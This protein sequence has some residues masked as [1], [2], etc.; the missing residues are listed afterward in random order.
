[1]KYVS[2]PYINYEL[3]KDIVS[4][5]DALTDR[6]KRFGAITDATEQ[7]DWN[8][9]VNEASLGRN[10]VFFDASGNP[11][12]LV[13]VESMPMNLLQ[14]GWE[15]KSHYAFIVNNVVKDRF[16]MGKYQGV[17][18]GSGAESRVVCLRGLDPGNSDWSLQITFDD[19]LTA[20]IQSGLCLATNAM[21][22]FIALR[23]LARG[24]MPRGNNNYGKDVSV[25]SETAVPSFIYSNQVARCATGTGP[26]SWADDGTPFGIFDIN[27]NVWE[28]AAGLRLLDGEI[29][30]IPDNNAALSTTDMSVSSTAW[31]AIMPDGTLVAPGTTGTLKYDSL[32]PMTNDGST[33]D[34]GAFTL[35]TTLQ[36]APDPA[37]NWGNNY[38]DSNSMLF[39]Q[40]TAEVSVPNILKQLRLFPT[41]SN[42]GGDNWWIRNYGERL[43]LVGAHWSYGSRAGVFA[44]YLNF[45]RSSLSFG[46]GFRPALVV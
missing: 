36:N 22:A 27:G 18:I 4:I 8:K 37:W 11:S 9:R 42:H 7:K 32:V 33:Q 41:S 31:Q 5:E 38:Y 43:P 1:M 2:G 45:H 44:V 3:K 46:N 28:W 25:P 14:S 6:Y 20:C 40:I 13:K 26:D 35:R 30:I 23:C 21:Y 16:Y 10:V 29:Q 15:N 34:L 19:S 24:F 17:N 12:V 39:E